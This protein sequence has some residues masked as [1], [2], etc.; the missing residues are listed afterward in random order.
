M[1]LKIKSIICTALAL[2]MTLSICACGRQPKE[3]DASSSTVDISA[4]EK[5]PEISE[6][7]A[8]EADESSESAATAIGVQKFTNDAGTSIDVL[9]EEIGGTAAQFGVAY[10]GYFDSEVAGETGIDLS[11]W[12]SSAASPLN[13][14]Y[15]FVS[16][17]DAAH[18]VGID[19]DMF[20]IIA[21]D[22]EASIEVRDTGSDEVLYYAENGDPIL[23]LSNMDVVVTVTAADGSA[24]HW[25]PE[26]DESGYPQLL[27]GDEREI[28]FMDFT[29]TEPL[30][31]FDAD[32]LLDEGWLGMSDIGLANDRYGLNW[33]FDSADGD[34]SYCLSFYLEENGNYDGEVLL[35]CYDS[36]NTMC[37]HWQGY[38][39]IE[40]ELDRPSII[41]MD[42][43]FIGGEGMASSEVPEIIAGSYWAMIHPSGE[44]LLLAVEDFYAPLLPMLSYD[45]PTAEFSLDVY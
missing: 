31:S 10:I 39:R 29:C 21:K 38:W 27:I 11:Q 34:S 43:E 22:Y 45:M 19:G 37:A 20:C 3:P 15:P 35:E 32:S 30:N 13:S 33:W 8:V 23:I 25:E 26:L 18:T 2:I 5:N 14:Y 9:R 41:Y 1:E 24:Y 6:S 16:E 12:F 7:S 40:T 42:M 4:F 36:D 44:R 17:I 28:I